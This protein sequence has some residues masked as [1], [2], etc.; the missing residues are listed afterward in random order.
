MLTVT[1]PISSLTV[2]VL[3]YQLGE[4]LRN[5]TEPFFSSS[6]LL[7]FFFPHKQLVIY[8]EMTLQLVNS[9]EYGKAEE[10][11]AGGQRLF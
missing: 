6:L 4:P 3:E 11:A 7:M 2:P 8:L 5:S 1:H 9:L 10:G